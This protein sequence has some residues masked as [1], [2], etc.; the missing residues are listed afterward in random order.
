M[1]V[2]DAYVILEQMDQFVFVI[3]A[4]V[5]QKGA[6]KRSIEYLKLAG[7]N[8]TGVVFNQVDQSKAS[9]DEQFDYYQQYYGVDE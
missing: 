5:T 9:K 8:E 4:A 7:L 6:L 1:A 3:R 2:T